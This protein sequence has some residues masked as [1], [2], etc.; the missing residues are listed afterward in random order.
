MFR[1]LQAG[2]NIRCVDF[3]E[4]LLR[5]SPNVDVALTW[6]ADKQKA[7]RDARPK[8]LVLFSKLGFWSLTPPKSDASTTSVT[9]IRAGISSHHTERQKS[10]R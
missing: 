10:P 6:N 5:D 1:Q 2:A 3:I 8:A 4:Y 9:D 7:P